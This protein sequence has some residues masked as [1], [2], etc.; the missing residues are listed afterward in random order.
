MG[1]AVTLSVG[2]C[3]SIQRNVLWAEAYTAIPS[4]TLIHPIVWPQYTSVTDRTDKTEQTGR[5]TDRQTDNGPI[6]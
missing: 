2:S 3:V 6:E 4:G 1:A 5:Q